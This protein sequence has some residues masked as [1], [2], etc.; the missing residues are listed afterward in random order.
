MLLTL[1]PASCLDPRSMQWQANG[2]LDRNEL[3]DLVR[4]L[5]DVE[6][7]ELRSEL[8]RLSSQVESTD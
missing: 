3:F 2:E 5:G 6:G 8:H 1:A 4:L 7:P